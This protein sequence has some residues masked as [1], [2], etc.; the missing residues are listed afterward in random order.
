MLCQ[1]VI[2]FYCTAKK[3]MISQDNNPKE[4]NAFYFFFIGGKSVQWPRAASAAKPT[5][6]PRVGCG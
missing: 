4:G 1:P 5:D 3:V 2:L 6:S